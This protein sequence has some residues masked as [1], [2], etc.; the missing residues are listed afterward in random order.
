M[1]NI[2]VKYTPRSFDTLDYVLHLSV[3]VCVYEPDSS[4][5]NP[6]LPHDAVRFRRGLPA[7]VNSFGPQS[8]HCWGSNPFWYPLDSH[9][10]HLD[11]HTHTEK[12]ITEQF[13]LMEAW[14]SFSNRMSLVVSVLVFRSGRLL[15][16][17]R[18]RWLRFFL[19]FYFF[20]L[21]PVLCL[22]AAW[23]RH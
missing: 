5:V 19:S 2:T 1:C 15:G 7:D 17:G 14:I 6:I 21:S 20:S 18:E 22:F 12:G 3:R 23:P 11:T 4:L 13:A 8:A 16:E 9:C 10:H